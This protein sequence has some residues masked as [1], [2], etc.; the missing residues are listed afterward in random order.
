MLN[1]ILG[2][3]IPWLTVMPLARWAVVSLLVWR[4]AGYWF[5][6]F[7][8]GLTTINRRCRRLPSSTVRRIGNE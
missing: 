5:V 1:S 4:G 2:T 8:A 6:I 7:L 3:E